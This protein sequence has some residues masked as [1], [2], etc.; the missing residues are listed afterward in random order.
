MSSVPL[1]IRIALK[2]FPLGL[3][4]LVIR[5]SSSNNRVSNV[6]GLSTPP[7]TTGST[8][9]EIYSVVPGGQW[10]DNENDTLSM[11]MHFNQQGS[12]VLGGDLEF[13]L[14]RD[15]FIEGSGVPPNIPYAEHVFFCHFCN[16]EF[17]CVACK[18][19]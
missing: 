9:A 8:S 3:F 17:C 11:A 6:V 10:N 18:H 16:A 12:G 4:P 13:L 5:P 15:D 19:A 2:A 7:I 1:T 14:D